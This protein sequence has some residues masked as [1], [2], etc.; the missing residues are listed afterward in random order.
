MSGRE[1]SP[2]FDRGDEVSSDRRSRP[3]DL[4]GA[5][6]RAWVGYQLQLD[7]Q[8]AVAGFADRSF[9][10]GRVLRFCAQSEE[11]TASQIGRELGITRQG[12]GKVV[13]ALRD[14]GYVTLRT[15][16]SDRR[17]KVVSL[18]P[19]AHDYLAA[20]RSASR[21]I[22]RLLRRQIGS[23]GFERL[24][25]LLDALAGD[26]QPRMRDYFRRTLRVDNESD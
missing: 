4:G 6:R 18:T 20:Q 14:R 23:E 15:S 3:P 21:K 5:L 22:E 7:R 8:L 10:D 12:A 26:D 24:L 13:A 11:V 2:S 17:E 19:R 25:Q 1:L 16:S 9:P